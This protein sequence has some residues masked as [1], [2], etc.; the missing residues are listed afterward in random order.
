MSLRTIDEFWMLKEGSHPHMIECDHCHG[1]GSSLKDP[2]HVG[3]CSKCGG[4]GYVKREV[5]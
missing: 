4:K 1:Y 5:E 3:N 2:E